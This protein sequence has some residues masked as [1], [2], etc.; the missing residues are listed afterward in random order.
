L[1]LVR[2]SLESAFM[3]LTHD[4]VQYRAGGDDAAT[5]ATARAGS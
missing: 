1:S 3:E 2:A 5:A 4:S